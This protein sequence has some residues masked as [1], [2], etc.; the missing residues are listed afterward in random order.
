MQYPADPFHFAGSRK[1]NMTDPDPTL[2]KQDHK[3]SSLLR[4]NCLQVV[5]YSKEI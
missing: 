4:Q 3:N 2:K 1:N 5:I